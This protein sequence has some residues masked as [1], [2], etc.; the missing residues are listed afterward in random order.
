[1][2]LTGEQMKLTII[3]GTT[4]ILLFGISVI[5]LFNMFSKKSQL[6]QKE[7]E[8][9]KANFE[10]DILQAQ[11]EIQEHTFTSISQEIHDNVGQILSL[12][13][14]QVEL[15]LMNLPENAPT[16][17]INEVKE[18]IANAIAN[19]RDLAK[20]LSSDRIM[21]LSIDETVAFELDKIEK[22]G[23]CQTQL[24]RN[25]SEQEISGP[26]KLILFRII[27][28]SLQNIMKHA[29]ATSIIIT[30]DYEPEVLSVTIADNGKGF[31]SAAVMEKGDGL[32]LINIK[33]RA[34]LAGGSAQINSHPGAG[35]VV[36]VRIPYEQTIT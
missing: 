21:Y 23:V 35:S 32:G 3:L 7:K 12:A 14:I 6:N 27:Q 19:L 17:K 34:A 33:K 28:E 24:L 1:M 16:A 18:N 10:K 36:Q 31:D 4:I 25:G 20:G 9:L 5:A 15:Y 11:L 22:S 13:K 2:S 29:S 8:I 26:K 30:I